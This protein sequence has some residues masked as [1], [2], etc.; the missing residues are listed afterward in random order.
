MNRASSPAASSPRD[1]RRQ[2]KVQQIIT[3]ATEVF[4][5]DGFVGASMDRI[6]ELAGVSKRTLYNYYKSK[7]EIFVDV[8]QKQLGSI[9]QN[10]E[11]GQLESMTL[12]QQLQHL[13]TQ[14]LELSNAPETLALFR[15][16]AA[17]A[18]RFPKLAHEFLEQSC[19]QVIAGIAEICE[20][21]GEKAGLKIADPL[22]AAE[23]FLDLITGSAFHRVVFGTTPPM[24][25]QKMRQ[26]AEKAVEYFFKAYR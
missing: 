11:P 23:H 9:Y 26:R 8:M 14:M 25:K 15:N 2:E 18:R 12:E 22:E 16:M 19:E 4:A 3:A 20:R 21:E 13:G 1:Q 24:T 7:D 5:E 17:E 6:V 10:F